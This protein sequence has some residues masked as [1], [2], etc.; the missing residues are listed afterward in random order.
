MKLMHNRD[1]SEPAAAAAQLDLQACLQ[2]AREERRDAGIEATSRRLLA[3]GADRLPVVRVDRTLLWG[4]RRIS[5]FLAAGPR[6]ETRLI[7]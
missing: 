2:A 1:G 4:E 6:R 3:L 7:S 5:A